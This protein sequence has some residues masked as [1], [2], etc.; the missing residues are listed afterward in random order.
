MIVFVN[1]NNFLQV[2]YK[3]LLRKEGVHVQKLM[4][5]V[6]FIFNALGK[7]HGLQSEML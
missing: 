7:N 6:L 5:F 4:V 2:S 1:F 3:L